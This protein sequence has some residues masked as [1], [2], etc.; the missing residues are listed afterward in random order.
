VKGATPTVTDENEPQ[1]P[2][3]RNWDALEKKAKKA[4]ALERQLEQAQRD[5]AFLRA[6]ID[7]TSGLGELLARTYEGEP[8]A[9]AIREYATRYSYDF[10]G[11]NGA[12]QV[13]EDQRERLDSHDRAEQVQRR[14]TPQGQA[15]MTP[16]E[17]RVLLKAD[18]AAAYQAYKDGRV[19]GMSPEVLS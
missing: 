9:D 14:S 17:H 13:S 5:I 3:S 7:T 16:D 10:T 15:R 4:D 1:T 18:P 11:T 2:N 6:G 12:A 19:E 8:D